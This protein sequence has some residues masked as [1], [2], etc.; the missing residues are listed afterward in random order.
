MKRNFDAVAEESEDSLVDEEEDL[1][2]ETEKPVGST[3]KIG[4]KAAE[5]GENKRLK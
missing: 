3:L 2:A 5:G 4:S 1:E